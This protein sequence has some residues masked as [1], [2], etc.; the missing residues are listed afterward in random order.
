MKAM[1][2]LV[3]SGMVKFIGVSNFSIKLLKKAESYAKNK[4]VA[5]QV[6]YNL[7]RRGP[8]KGLL[9]Y[10]QKKGIM[11][12]AYQPLAGGILTKPGFKV[13]DDLAKKYKKTQAQI[14]INWLISKPNVITI[15]KA[16]NISHIKENIG[17]LHWR[18]NGEDYQK[19]DKYFR[20]FWFFY[21][22][23]WK[24]M[25]ISKRIIYKKLSSTQKETLGPLYDKIVDTLS[26]IKKGFR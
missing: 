1:D 12:I 10:C 15:P 20:K 2:F 24:Y 13:L 23:L 26:K 22:F 6:E 8:E 25:R 16:A 3:E 9:R 21:D 7:L 11:L 4:I 5:N 17:A 18:L 19:L 14:A